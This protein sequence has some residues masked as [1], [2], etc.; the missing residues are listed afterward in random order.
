[1]I[2]QQLKKQEAD[3]SALS[4][5]FRKNLND[6][7]QKSSQL[8]S[9]PLDYIG[10]YLNQTQSTLEKRLL[11]EH[12]L[13]PRTWFLSSEN[14]E[15][16]EKINKLAQDCF[17]EVRNLSSYEIFQYLTAL[18]TLQRFYYTST[19]IEL[20]SSQSI[21]KDDPQYK[22]FQNIQEECFYYSIF[23]NATYGD[24]MNYV[25]SGKDIGRVIRVVNYDKEFLNHVKIPPTDLL[26][27]SWITQPYKPG[28]CIAVDRQSKSIVLCLRGTNDWFDILT[29]LDS[30][31][32]EFDIL[33]LEDERCLR[34]N[35]NYD[36]HD[37]IQKKIDKTTKY[38]L[39]NSNIELK[40]NEKILRSG[41][42]HSGMMTSAISLYKELVPM[43]L[44]LLP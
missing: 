6:V 14:V 34:F 35:F 25:Y 21:S 3:Q 4:N 12:N 1:L 36:F 16:L 13:D 17:M 9:K 30:N 28:Y 29:D 27:S 5:G 37:H 19:K 31:F 26:Y 40:G 11:V 22:E 43:V 33:E 39:K 44:I 38:L 32:L 2:Q 23:A 20:P 10:D 7:F 42:C 18:S 15:L 8:V 24:L 41:F